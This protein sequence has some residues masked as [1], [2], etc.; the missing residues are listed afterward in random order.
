M[1]QRAAKCW[2]EMSGTL[3]E[4]SPGELF[5]GQNLSGD[6]GTGGREPLKQ[7]SFRQAFSTQH[8]YATLCA[9]QTPT[10]VAI[11]LRGLKVMDNMSKHNQRERVSGVT[12]VGD[13]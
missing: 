9:F 13:R 7:L 2:H 5:S 10:A 11:G 12:Q 8:R 4:Q 6:L 1:G 3:Q